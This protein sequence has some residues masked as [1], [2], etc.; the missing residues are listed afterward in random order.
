MDTSV[1]RAPGG[2]IMAG[3]ERL[4]SDVPPPTKTMGCSGPI[5]PAWE[6]QTAHFGSGD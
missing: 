2:L 5:S 3:I 6:G 1:L 4:V